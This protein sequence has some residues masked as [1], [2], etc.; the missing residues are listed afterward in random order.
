[1]SPNDTYL[2]PNTID[3]ESTKESCKSKI[4][5]VRAWFDLSDSQARWH[6]HDL[7]TSGFRVVP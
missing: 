2:N 7:V 6:P 4:K 1:L 3:A 5:V